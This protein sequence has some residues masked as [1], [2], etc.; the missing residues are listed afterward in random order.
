MLAK[1]G[2][3]T[4]IIALNASIGNPAI[5]TVN[6]GEADSI[7]F[8]SALYGRTIGITSGKLVIT[9]DLIVSFT[10]SLISNGYNF[11][12]EFG[13]FGA[14]FSPAATD[15]VDQPT[16]LLQL[17]RLQDNG[18]SINTIMPDAT[19]NLVDQGN[20]SNAPIV[21][22]RGVHR[23]QPKSGRPDIGTVKVDSTDDSTS[24]ALAA[25]PQALMVSTP[26]VKAS[27]SANTPF[28]T[29]IE[30]QPVDPDAINNAPRAD[31]FADG[32]SE[33]SV[34]FVSETASNLT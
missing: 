27:Q 32:N 17:D 20:S 3:L 1:Y 29:L 22:Q 19:S 9:S 6:A 2:G 31:L 18:G 16:T 14:F 24:F 5:D 26:E 11:I 34:A 23:P 8:S 28:P 21:D 15:A 4:Q 25:T 13:D 33:I 30:K 10:S 12:G 7:G